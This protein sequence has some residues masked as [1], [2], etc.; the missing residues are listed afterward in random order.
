MALAFEGIGFLF[1]FIGQKGEQVFVKNMAVPGVASP[2]FERFESC[3]HAGPAEERGFGV[4]LSEFA[5][6]NQTGFLHDLVHFGPTGE[7]GS[8]KSAERGFGL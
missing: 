5:P 2:H 3:D 4:V 7:Q 6:E 1:G 8:N